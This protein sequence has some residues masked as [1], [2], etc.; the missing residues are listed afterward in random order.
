VQY[1]SSVSNN[2]KADSIEQPVSAMKPAVLL[3]ISF[4]ENTALS[5]SG[6]VYF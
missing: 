2:K 4:H 3:L 5:F 6:F 1:C